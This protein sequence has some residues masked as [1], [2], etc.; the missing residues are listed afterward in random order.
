MAL[1]LL[2]HGFRDPRATVLKPAERKVSQDIKQQQQQQQQQLE[3]VTAAWPYLKQLQAA[4]VAVACSSTD[5]S[6]ALS[7]MGCRVSQSHSPAGPAPASPGDRLE[8]VQEPCKQQLQH[9]NEPSAAAALLCFL[10]DQLARGSSSSH[11]DSNG[12]AAGAANAPLQVPLQA[13][14]VQLP[15][16]VAAVLA[17]GITS[18]SSSSDGASVC[19]SLQHCLVSMAAAALQQLE[20]RGAR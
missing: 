3:G 12:I 2:L 13:Q 6:S 9:G 7:A 17:A 11:G 1:L 10:Q 8:Q 4:E 15:T 20:E 19:T 18:S 5:S 16:Q 14:E